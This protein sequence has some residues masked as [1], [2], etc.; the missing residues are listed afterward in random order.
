MSHPRGGIARD[1]QRATI[2]ELEE[3]VVRLSKGLASALKELRSR[4]AL[5]LAKPSLAM[6][7]EFQEVAT[8][9]LGVS[10]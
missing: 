8:N 7:K 4:G 3:K 10:G 9:D 5:R 1:L 6:L 2:V